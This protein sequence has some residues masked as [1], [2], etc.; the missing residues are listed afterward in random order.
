MYGLLARTHVRLLDLQ[1]RLA[2]DRGE[3]IFSH[4]ATYVIVGVSAGAAVPLWKAASSALGN[5]VGSL[6]TKVLGLG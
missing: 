2:D 3:G 6:V 1:R 5:G 4:G